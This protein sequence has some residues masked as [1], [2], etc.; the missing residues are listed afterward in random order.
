MRVRVY[1]DAGVVNGIVLTTDEHGREVQ[2]T[3]F[4]DVLCGV[5]AADRPVNAQEN[6]ISHE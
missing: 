4:T 1:G 5:T 3:I 6:L 2:R